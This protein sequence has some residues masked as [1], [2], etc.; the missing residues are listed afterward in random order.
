MGVTWREIQLILSQNSF[1]QAPWSS[2]IIVLFCYSGVKFISTKALDD[3]GNYAGVKWVIKRGLRGER[4]GK[5]GVG[6]G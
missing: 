2:V 1:I 6:K 4:R 3:D 5:L